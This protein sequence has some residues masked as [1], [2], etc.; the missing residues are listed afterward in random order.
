VTQPEQDLVCLIMAAGKGTR[1]KSDSAKVLARL[2]GKT[3]LGYV[4]ESIRDL[5]PSRVVAVVG[6]DRES[7][8]RTFA[9]QGLTFVVQAKQLGTGHAVQ[10]AEH[11]ILDDSRHA[12]LLILSGDMPLIRSQ[13]LERFC[14]RHRTSHADLTLLTARPPDPSGLGRVVRDDVGRV[15]EIVEEKDIQSDAVRSIREVNL[16]IYLARP[17]ALFAALHE[18]KNENAQGEFYLPD[19]VK[20][21]RDQGARVEAWCGAEPE[22]GM[23]V[24]RPREL[25]RAAAVLRQRHVDALLDAGVQILD[26][27]N[28][29]IADDAQVGTGTVIHPFS[30]LESGCVVGES[31]EI[32]PFVRICSGENVADGRKVEG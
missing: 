2:G 24:N 6:H 10:M 27:A 28:T 7:V 31:C 29:V 22:E 25:A 18:V 15:V 19:V 32:G 5:H 26:P 14:G 3:L 4:L 9:G 17:V 20:I 13:T 16:G 12:D 11:A 21:L 8:E 30:I 23:G 1:M